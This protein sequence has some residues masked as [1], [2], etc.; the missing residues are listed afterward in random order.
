MTNK[1]LLRAL[2]CF[3]QPRDRNVNPAEE[4]Q[5]LYEAGEKKFIGTDKVKQSMHE[6]KI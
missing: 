2:L 4:A 6:L 5:R 3:A 1:D